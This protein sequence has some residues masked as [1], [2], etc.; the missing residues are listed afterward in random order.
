MITFDPYD[1]QSMAAACRALADELDAYAAR[2]PVADTEPRVNLLPMLP[3]MCL[4]R[5]RARCVLTAIELRKFAVRLDALPVTQEAWSAVQTGTD[6]EYAAWL[7][8]IG[9]D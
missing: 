5:S 2:F 9:L 7:A 3:L 4:T 8:S 6:S 1:A